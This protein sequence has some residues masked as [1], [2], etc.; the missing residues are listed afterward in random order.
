MVALDPDALPVGPLSMSAL[1]ALEPPA[2]RR[3]LKSGLRRG[4]STVDLAALLEQEW[5]WRLD[6]PPAQALLAALAQRGW[7][8][9]NGEIWKTRVG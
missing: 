1:V 4:V 7:F 2:L 9:S 8:E 6:S 5:Q 3:L